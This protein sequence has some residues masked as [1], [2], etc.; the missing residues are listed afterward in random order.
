MT[1]LIMLRCT[2]SEAA[3]KRELGNIVSRARVSFSRQGP[4]LNPALGS[5]ARRG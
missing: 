2:S 4:E 1:W 5:E 3:A